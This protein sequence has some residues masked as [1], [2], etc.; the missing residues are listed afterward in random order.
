MCLSTVYLREAER[1]EP[2]AKNIAAVKTRDD[3]L[4]LTDIMGVTTEVDAEIEL[5]DLMENVIYLRHRE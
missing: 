2:V 5:V 4:L 3:K 1:R